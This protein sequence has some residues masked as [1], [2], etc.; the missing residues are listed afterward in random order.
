MFKT[1]IQ[2]SQCREHWMVGNRERTNDEKRHWVCPK[3]QELESY[4]IRSDEAKIDENEQEEKVQSPKDEPEF[5][6]G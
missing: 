3:C 5:Y 4:K 6:N 2:C 1:E